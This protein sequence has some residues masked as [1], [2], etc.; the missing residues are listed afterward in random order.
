MNVER[1]RA[2]FRK[3]TPYALAV[4]ALGAAGTAAA[5]YK[6]AQES[7]CK[8]GAAC[9]SPGSPCCNHAAEDRVSQR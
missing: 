1:A 8:P 4:F 9:C 7:C 3:A 6:D 5:R 2:L